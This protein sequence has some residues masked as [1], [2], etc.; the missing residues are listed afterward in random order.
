VTGPNPPYRQIAAAVR[1]R[2]VTG[3][4][5]P[6]DRVP[7]ARQLTREFGVAIATATK[8]LAELRRDGL[9]RAVPGVG[10]VVAAPEPPGPPVVDAGRRDPSPAPTPDRRRAGR[11]PAAELSRERIVR[12]A[13]D[14]ADAE[15]MAS[16]SMR[17]VAMALDV[18]TMSL[19]RHVR[20]KDELV[21]FMI[22]TA[23]GEERLPRTPPA[24]W[25]AALDHVSR[26]QW[27]LFRRHR[28]LGPA[29]SLT[30]PQIAPN[31]ILHTEWV[32]RVLHGL[33]LGAAAMMHVHTTLFIFVRGLA[34]S[35]ETEAE[36]ERDTGMTSD[37]WI[38]TQ[39]A[40][41]TAVAASGAFEMFARLL[42]ETD[43]D[44]D[45]D[46]LFEFGLA[47]LLDGFAVLL[48]SVKSKGDSS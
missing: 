10:T 7:S 45:V 19:Y 29:L 37:E 2:I 26:L 21:L 48:R 9:V 39:E 27:R 5:R 6:G 34:T 32:L 17:R 12:A 16:L 1:R 4:L 35:L 18:A 44:M 30:R 25:R 14:I 40:A 36:A 38:E 11:E 41:F 46:T 47:R 31:A 24:D 23:I 13:I 28:W 15:G 42:R 22:D 8:V 20:G 43:V 33:G 3:E